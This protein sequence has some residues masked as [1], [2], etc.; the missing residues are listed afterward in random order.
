MWAG[1]VCRYSV[2]GRAS[3]W[4]VRGDA[5]GGIEHGVVFEGAGDVLHSHYF[6]RPSAM[7]SPPH[8]TCIS[9]R[10]R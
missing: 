3:G 10:L 5:W 7:Y 9:S 6:Q 2:G 1:G 8:F 4:G